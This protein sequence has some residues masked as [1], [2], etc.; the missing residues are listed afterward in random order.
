MALALAGAVAMGLGTGAF[1][2]NLAPVLM[3]T[4]PRSHLAR[5]QAL[6]SLAQ[7]G[8]LLA[9]NNVLGA[10]AHATSPAAAMIT[11][12]TAIGGCAVAA[13]LVPAIRQAGTPR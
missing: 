12:A 8:A 11:C 4:A 5:I 1:T 6:L 7:S 10:V 2:C 3:G 9:F 13:L